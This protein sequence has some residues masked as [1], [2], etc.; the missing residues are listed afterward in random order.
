[1]SHDGDYGAEMRKPRALSDRQVEDFFTGSVA[2]EDLL[3]SF[4]HAARAAATGPAPLP[5]G[6]LARILADGLTIDKGDLPVMAASKASGPRGEVSG[7][8]KWR[9]PIVATTTLITTL[10]AKVGMASAAAKAGLATAA[11]AGAFT[12]AGAAGAL[13]A[14]VQN[15]VSH[16]VSAVTPVH[17]PTTA[18]SH[19]NP[20]THQPS[21]QSGTHGRPTSPGSV[22]LAQANSGPAAGHA[23]TSTPGGKPSSVDSGRPTSPGSGGLAQANSGPAAGHAPTST[24]A[25]AGSASSRANGAPP[26]P[27]AS[28][29]P[30]GHGVGQAGS[31]PPAGSS[32][33][34]SRIPTS[35][36]AS[37]S[38]SHPA[39]PTSRP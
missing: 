29:E 23:P 12:A 32:A 5:T 10:I 15:A 27:F 35:L 1:M 8:P 31:T 26:A 11:L 9:R 39:G 2:G 13:P 17:L 36:P 28:A 14:P 30:S 3:T 25:A 33:A 24:P 6:E 4:A 22:G 18:N 20:G 37:G 38:A 16:A 7:L 34:T 19:A 21:S